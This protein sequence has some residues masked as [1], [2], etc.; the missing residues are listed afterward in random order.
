MR[1]VH[2][3][4]CFVGILAVLCSA[5]AQQQTLPNSQQFTDLLR[6]CAAGANIDI[7]ADLVGSLKTIYD[8]QRTQ[9]AASFKSS[10]D[11]LKLIPDAQRLEAYKLYTQCVQGIISGKITATN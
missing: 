11:F 10:A 7:S 8:G 1:L 9:G 5:Q 6:G 2:L 3:S 4:T